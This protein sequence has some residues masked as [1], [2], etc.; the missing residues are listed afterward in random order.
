MSRRGTPTPVA[1]ATKA[2]CALIPSRGEA[3]SRGT[4]G[5]KA[6]RV[7][8]ALAMTCDDGRAVA[9]G[10]N[11]SARGKKTGALVGR[12]RVNTFFTPA[13]FARYCPA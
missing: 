4:L 11:K 6:S 3:A 2:R 5:T 1:A 10:R 13:L 9:L 12:R 7:R 8:F